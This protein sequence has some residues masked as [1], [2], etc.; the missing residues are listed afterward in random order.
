[1]IINNDVFGEIASVISSVFI[2]SA[3]LEYILKVRNKE[4]APRLASWS[5]WTV[6]TLVG[7][8]S[9]AL[10]HQL[11]ATIFGMILA[12]TDGTVVFFGWRDGDRKLTPLDYFAILIGT[13]GIILLSSAIVFPGSIPLI[14]IVITT[15][16]TDVIAF[17]PTYI[18]AL[19]GNEVP[20]PYVKYAIASALIICAAN[21]SEILGIIYPFYIF[22]SCS[23]AAWLSMKKQ[24]QLFSKKLG[25]SRF[26]RRLKR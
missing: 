20:G 26:V 19:K 14:A 24:N 18:N 12:V 1:M 16:V 8:I 11:P 3:N 2:A 17:I 6:A 22:F 4:V 15:I 9:T 13:L 21:F 23:F 10:D 7:A 5:I 25:R